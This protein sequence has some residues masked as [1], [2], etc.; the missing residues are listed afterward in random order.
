MS[1]KIKTKPKLRKLCLTLSA[2]YFF[3]LSRC[4]EAISQAK[5]GMKDDL[6]VEYRVCRCCMPSLKPVTMAAGHVVAVRVT[7]GEK[8]DG[9]EPILVGPSSVTAVW[10]PLAGA[11]KPFSPRVWRD[12]TSCH[13]KTFLGPPAASP[14]H[15]TLVSRHWCVEPLTY[16]HSNACSSRS[17]TFVIT[18]GQHLVT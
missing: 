18:R 16:R 15:V 12:L 14:G 9:G 7:L 5:C 2:F 4:E 1:F 10:L 8:V 6:Y 13:W 11:I 17:A 3:C